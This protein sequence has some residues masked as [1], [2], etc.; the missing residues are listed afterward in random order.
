MKV[1]R[2]CQCRSFAVGNHNS[3][4]FVSHFC[5][6][7]LVEKMTFYKSK[8]MRPNIYFNMSGKD[9]SAFSEEIPLRLYG[10]LNS[11]LDVLLSFISGLMVDMI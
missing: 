10:Q 5:F 2:L 1:Q 3:F 11:C 4:G 8:N 9:P 7:I 6:N